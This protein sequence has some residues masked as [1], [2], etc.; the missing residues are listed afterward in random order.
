MNSYGYGGRVLRIDLSERKYSVR[1]LSPS[2]FKPVI[3]GRAANT[4]R[5]YEELDPDC[6]PL[7][8]ENV[9]IFGIGP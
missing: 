7:G 5:L 4:K 1:D 3:G 9:L 8:P 6:D 2:W